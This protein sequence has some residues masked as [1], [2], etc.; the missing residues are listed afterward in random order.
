[1]NPPH[2]LIVNPCILL[3]RL[4][5]ATKIEFDFVKKTKFKKEVS[6]RYNLAPSTFGTLMRNGT[7]FREEFDKIIRSQRV[8]LKRPKFGDLE[9]SLVKW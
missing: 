6:L 3:V 5:I 7:K 1:M 8:T 9:A 4:S 2:R